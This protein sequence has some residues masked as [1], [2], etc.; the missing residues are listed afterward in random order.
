MALDVQSNV[1]TD[2]PPAARIAKDEAEVSVLPHSDGFDVLIRV[3][4]TEQDGPATAHVQVDELMAAEGMGRYF[5]DDDQ[6]SP[7]DVINALNG[8][9][10][11]VQITTVRREIRDGVEITVSLAGGT[12]EIGPFF[13]EDVAVELVGEGDDGHVEW[14]KNEDE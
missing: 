11:N 10:P 3:P 8:L 1:V 9:T 12:L 7:E 6:R 5:D 13:G 14:K 4:G 2:E